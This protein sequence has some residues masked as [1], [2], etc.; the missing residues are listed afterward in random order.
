MFRHNNKTPDEEKKIDAHS[1]SEISVAPLAVKARTSDESVTTAD[2]KELLEK[3]L[4]WSQ[5]I[6]EQ[7]RKLNNKLLWAAIASWM[8]ILLI[9]IPLIAALLFLPPLLKDVWSQYGDLLGVSS[10]KS[11]ASHADLD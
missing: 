10:G 4:K 2:L 6:Y 1:E 5:I 9:V 8:R 3:N 11:G 7:N